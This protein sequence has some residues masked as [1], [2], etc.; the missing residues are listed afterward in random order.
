[1]VSLTDS[2]CCVNDDEEFC[3][4]VGN[5]CLELEYVKV[6]ALPAAAE[7]VFSR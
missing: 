2:D 6:R 3:S 4:A 7:V 5:V 1:M